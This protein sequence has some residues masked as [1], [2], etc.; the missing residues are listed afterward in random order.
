M[1]VRCGWSG[2]LKD[3]FTGVIASACRLHIVLALLLEQGTWPVNKVETIGDMAHEMQVSG[4]DA[5]SVNRIAHRLQA[6][7]SNI[8]EDPTRLATCP[9]SRC[10][11][12]RPWRIRVH[13]AL[14]ALNEQETQ[15]N[16]SYASGPT[17]SPS[18]CP[19]AVRNHHGADGDAQ[20]VM[21]S[22]NSSATHIPAPTPDSTRPSYAARGGFR[23]R[24]NRLLLRL[25][26]L[27]QD[28]RSGDRG[29]T[30]AMLATTETTNHITDHSATS[31]KA[32]RAAT[33]NILYTAVNS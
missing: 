31:V 16:G 20:A 23:G 5:P 27:Y 29:G 12:R 4:W 22:F 11:C 25:Q 32:M 24:G 2:S 3:N 33:Y 19:E 13:Q 28:S 17:S 7:D 30:D 15:R 8:F 14:R 21:G 26:L 10:R 1:S 18:N 6:A 9:A